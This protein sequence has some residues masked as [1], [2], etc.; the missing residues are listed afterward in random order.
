MNVLGSIFAKCLNKETT[1][2]LLRDRIDNVKKESRV[3]DSDGDIDDMGAFEFIGEIQ[4][5]IDSIERGDN[6]YKVR[7]AAAEVGLENYLVWQ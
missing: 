2:I 1:L 7:E 4:S 5:V 3:F 6:A